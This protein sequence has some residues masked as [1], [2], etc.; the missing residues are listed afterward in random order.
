MATNTYPVLVDPL[1]YQQTDLGVGGWLAALVDQ[2]D[3]A[4]FEGSRAMAGAIALYRE[5]QRGR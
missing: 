3:A 1:P 4:I 2:R 5:R